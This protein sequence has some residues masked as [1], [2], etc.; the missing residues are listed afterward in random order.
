[1]NFLAS[2]TRSDNDPLTLSGQALPQERNWAALRGSTLLSLSESELL[3]I[4]KDASVSSNAIQA[5]IESEDC[6]LTSRGPA[7]RVKAV[8]ARRNIQTSRTACEAE[9]AR[10]MGR[11]DKKAEVQALRDASAAKTERLQKN[12]EAG[13]ENARIR[14]EAAE[15]NA[16]AYAARASARAECFLGAAMDVLNKEQ[17]LAV[18]AKAQE[19]FPD[20]PGM[21]EIPS[22][23]ETARRLR[24]GRR[25]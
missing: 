25:R 11:A 3:D 20:H 8:N 12:I 5:Q 9:L 10:R 2:A 23:E 4:I 17:Y 18:W 6:G 16:K 13:A 24:E 15:M 21:T 22:V 19:M 1:M 14:K 7:W